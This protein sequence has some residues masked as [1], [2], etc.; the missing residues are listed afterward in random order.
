MPAHYLVLF[1]RLGAY[2][3]KRLGEIVYKR[4]EFTEQW[5]HEAS[6]VPMDLW[7]LLEHRRQ[8]F[9]PWSNSPIMK[10]T[11]KSKFLKQVMELIQ[12]GGAMTSRDLPPHPELPGCWMKV[13]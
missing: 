1:S 6:I 4:R 13:R 3:Q 12:A 2:D 9:K 11:G 10:L 7:P 8:E 5:A